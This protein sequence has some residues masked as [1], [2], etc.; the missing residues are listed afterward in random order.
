MSFRG[1]TLQKDLAVEALFAVLREEHKPRRMAIAEPGPHWECRFVEQGELTVAA[2]GGEERRVPEGFLFLRAPGETQTFRVPGRKS[3]RVLVIEFAARSPSLERCRSFLRAD[4]RQKEEIAAILNEKARGF[5]ETR[6]G[7]ARRLVRREDAPPG[8]GQLLFAHIEALLLSMLPVR[9]WKGAG[10]T[11]PTKDLFPF[12]AAYMDAHID[13][14]LSLSELAEVGGTSISTV[15]SVF[16]AETGEGAL[17]FFIR[18]KIARAE[19]YL[20]AGNMSATEIADA[21]GYESIHYF[22]RQF[23]GVTGM[24]P[25]AYAAH[26]R[27]SEKTS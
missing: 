6:D 18:K 7:S 16:R 5:S 25:S 21:L 19:E 10:N 8:C 3:A 15:K 27:G 9:A 24:S 1:V 12:L 23:R 17:S 20:A 11:L 13:S 4:S 14:R 2:R 26:I 22:S